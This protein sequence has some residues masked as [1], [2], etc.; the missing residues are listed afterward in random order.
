MRDAGCGMP[1]AGQLTVELL[2]GNRNECGVED[3]RIGTRFLSRWSFRLLLTDHRQLTTDD[4]HLNMPEDDKNEPIDLN[5][6]QTE[7]LKGRLG[8]LRRYL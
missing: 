6:F 2:E 8:E 5:A 4:R 7:D 1:D 3:F